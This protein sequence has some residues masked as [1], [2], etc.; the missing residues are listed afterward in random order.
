[1]K[2]EITIQEFQELLPSVCDRETS[3]DRE[4]WT[5]ENWAWGHCAVVA[6]LAQNVFGGDLLRSSLANDP[7]FYKGGSH[8]RNILPDGTIV[9]FTASQFGDDEPVLSGDVVRTRQSVLY[10][11]NDA[12][13]E[14]KKN[15]EST[16]KRYEL[17][18]W[19]YLKA[20]NKS[21]TFKV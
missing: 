19:R 2:S 12:L 13:D 3:Q 21:H 9:D 14:V 4:G 16:R 8:Y 10:P 6:L 15:F 18:Q 5:P 7:I 1:M 11:P 17:L 20:S